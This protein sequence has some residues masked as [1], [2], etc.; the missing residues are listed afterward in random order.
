MAGCR[1]ESPPAAV[2]G[3][4]YCAR[5]TFLSLSRQQGLQ[6]FMGCVGVA[7]MKLDSLSG[8]YQIANCDH[9]SFGVRANHISNKE[10]PRFEMILILACDS[11]DME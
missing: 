9:A 4:D 10:I 5:R 2:T 1:E 7:Y 6:I 3:E 11:T 8:S